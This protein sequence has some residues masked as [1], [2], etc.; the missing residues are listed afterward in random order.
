M[1]LYLD[2]AVFIN[3]RILP[4]D[5]NFMSGKGIRVSANILTD[6]LYEAW[7]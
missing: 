3:V 7:T 2:Q 6:C 1:G 5:Q 4:W